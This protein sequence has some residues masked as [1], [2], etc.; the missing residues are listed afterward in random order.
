M[1]LSVHDPPGLRLTPLACWISHPDLLH[2]VEELNLVLRH[3]ATVPGVL[4]YCANRGIKSWVMGQYEL[5]VPSHALNRHRGRQTH[6]MVFM[7][8]AGSIVSIHAE[9]IN[10]RVSQNDR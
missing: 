4:R 6:A 10:V 5:K 1:A 3:Y 9:K 7:K 8:L 2:E